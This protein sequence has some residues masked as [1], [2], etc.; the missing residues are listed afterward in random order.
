MHSTLDREHSRSRK[1]LQLTHQRLVQAEFA[2]RYWQEHDNLY[3][4][5][6]IPIYTNRADFRS[7]EM[8][9]IQEWQPNP[10]SISHSFANFSIRNGAFSRNPFS[11]PTLSSA[12]QHSGVV[13]DTSSLLKLSTRF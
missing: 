6:P 4:W 8:A 13:L 9:L 7:L 3:I 5:A 2:L 1:Y 12:L 10:N 11:T